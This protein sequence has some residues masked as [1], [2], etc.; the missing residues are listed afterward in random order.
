M[1]DIIEILHSACSGHSLLDCNIKHCSRENARLILQAS[2]STIF[3]FN[4][5]D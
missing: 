4:I 2:V 3:D 5:Q 1:V